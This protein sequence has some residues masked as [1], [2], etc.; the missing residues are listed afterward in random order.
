[1]IELMTED[2]WRNSEEATQ[3]NQYEKNDN[4]GIYFKFEGRW[5]KSILS[6]KWKGI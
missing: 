6:F 4:A 3:E 1:M 2:S 5:I